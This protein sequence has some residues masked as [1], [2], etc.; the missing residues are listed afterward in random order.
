MFTSITIDTGDV[1]V[2]VL[3]IFLT[4]FVNKKM[5]AI[6]DSYC[7]RKEE[8]AVIVK[9]LRT[10]GKLSYANSLAITECKTNGEMKDALDSYNEDAARLDDFI[11]TQY[12][13]AS[14]KK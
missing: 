6:D 2:S 10:I 9:M 4:I 11:L 13:G 14:A 1:V 8:T 7:T 3:I 5:K 12:A